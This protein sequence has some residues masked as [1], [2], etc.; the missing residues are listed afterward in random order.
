MKAKT[1][2]VK[3]FVEP[4][5][6]E[7]ELRYRRLFE[8]AQDGILILDAKTGAITDVNPY[9]IDMLGF[10]RD[11]FVDK[12]LWEVGAFKDIKASREAFEILQKDKYIRYEDLPLKA[13]DGHLIQVEFVSN[14]YSV[15]KHKVIQCNIRNINDR[16]RAEERRREQEIRYR[17]L[18]DN[19]PMGILLIDSQGRILEVNPGAL[20]ILGS[21]SA[22]ATKHIN[23]LTF[24]PL[25][26]AGI[27]ADYQKVLDNAQSAFGEYPYT[28]K[29][30]KSIFVSARLTPLFGPSGNLEQIQAIIEDITERKQAEEELR[31]REDKFKYVF[32][33][34]V[35][36]KSITFISGEFNPNKALCE[37]LGY[38]R[39]ELQNQRWQ[40][41]THPDDIEIVSKRA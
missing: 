19:A 26:E 30:G 28:T 7:S 21:P 22:E 5:L 3:T 18:F 17:L 36:G 29:W 10:S 11:E 31:D 4:S 1:K 20:Q 23:I 38:T 12:K 6:N 14:V 25:L 41:I 15:N 33:Y 40:D 27:S 8:A 2:K 37:M 35:V 32:D 34:S 9:L 13:K 24:Q 16:K 39:E